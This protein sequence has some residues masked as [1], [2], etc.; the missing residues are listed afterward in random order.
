[1]VE[2]FCCF[3]TYELRCKPADSREHSVRHADK[4]SRNT[5]SIYLFSTLSRVAAEVYVAETCGLHSNARKGQ[6]GG[7]LAHY[8]MSTPDGLQTHKTNA[9][10]HPK[11]HLWILMRNFY[12]TTCSVFPLVRGRGVPWEINTSAGSS[13]KTRHGSFCTNVDFCQSKW[14]QN[15]TLIFLLLLQTTIEQHVISRA[16]GKKWFTNKK[17]SLIIHLAS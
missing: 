5:F 8:S 6:L 11:G 9:A 13:A 15:S 10:A 14:R 12:W 4:P 16:V 2:Q 17:P 3:S 1:M 7:Q